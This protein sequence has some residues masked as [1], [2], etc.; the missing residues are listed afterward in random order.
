M[1]DED[2]YID[3]GLLNAILNADSVQPSSK[4]VT[5]VR[6]APLPV[7]TSPPSDSSSA[8]SSNSDMHGFVQILF[9]PGCISSLVSG[10]QLAWQDAHAALCTCRDARSSYTRTRDALFRKFIPGFA[11]GTRANHEPKVDIE[12]WVL[13]MISLSEPLHRYPT[14]ALTLLSSNG[15]PSPSEDSLAHKLE[16]LSL[17]HSRMMLLLRTRAPLVP[18][19][20]DLE[21]PPFRSADASSSKELSF[22]Q[23]LGYAAGEV[24]IGTPPTPPS[25]PGTL[26]GTR[27]NHQRHASAS[28]RLSRIFVSTPKAPP[29]APQRDKR[30]W[31]PSTVDPRE[32][33]MSRH[34]QSASM[35]DTES[36]RSIRASMYGLRSLASSDSGGTGTIPLSARSVHDPILASTRSRA[37]VLRLFV[38]C[39]RLDEPETLD[40]CSEQLREEGLWDFVSPGDVLCNLGHVPDASSS[41]TSSWIVVDSHRRL[42][43]W[44]PSDG[45]PAPL[46]GEDAL[47]CATPFYYAHLSSTAAAPSGGASPPYAGSAM[48]SRA[49]SVYSFAGPLSAS[50]PTLPRPPFFTPSHKRPGSSGGSTPT[51]PPSAWSA[52]YASP[53]TPPRVNPFSATQQPSPDPRWVLRIPP[54]EALLPAPAISGPAPANVNVQWTLSPQVGLVPLRSAGFGATARVKRY[55]WL[56]LVDLRRRGTRLDA[57]PVPPLPSWAAGGRSQQQPQKQAP[58]AAEE[59]LGVC[60]QREWVL[61][62]EG[63]REGRARL[64]A[65]LGGQ[66]GEERL[67]EIVRER[68]APGRLWMRLATYPTRQDPDEPGVNSPHERLAMTP[69]IPPRLQQ[70]QQQQQPRYQLPPVQFAAAAAAY[71]QDSKAH[72]AVALQQPPP[73]RERRVASQPHPD[74]ARR[75]SKRL[76]KRQPGDDQR[77][78]ASAERTPQPRLPQ[79]PREQ[80]PLP[81][82]S[83]GMQQWYGGDVAT[84][85]AQHPQWPAPR[86]SPS[87]VAQPLPVHAQ[88][89]SW[90]APP[91]VEHSLP[92]PPPP[93]Q[94]QPWSPVQQHNSRMKRESSPLNPNHRS[95]SSLPHDSSSSSL[96]AP[97][98]SSGS[99]TRPAPNEPMRMPA[100]PAV[101]AS[102]TRAL[103]ALPPGAA[104]PA[105]TPSPINTTLPSSHPPPP[106]P[107]SSFITLPS[108]SNSL[109]RSPPPPE[110]KHSP[111]PPLPPPKLSANTAN[112]PRDPSAPLSAPPLVRSAFGPATGLVPPPPPPPQTKRKLTRRKV[113]SALLPGR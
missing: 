64:E 84:P 58:S 28:S 21:D 82:V 39:A 38:P 29:P 25:Q 108:P 96:V 51:A 23:P 77:R 55:V 56:A 89:P 93:V 42:S 48:T 59:L 61:E 27:E 103:P 44:C 33:R 94:Q 10:G 113:V 19:Q 41:E 22:P 13:F 99:S 16:Q 87:T 17:A 57:P 100:L 1:R 101:L 35:S 26:R 24:Q 104:P 105:P 40:E 66:D 83:Q 80:R 50:T 74:T 79:Q 107:S 98:T 7:A 31:T 54:L 4:P 90:Y 111:P 18:R 43:V 91:A 53:P 72:M 95:S 20:S 11:Y 5:T 110:R 69:T 37:L 34:V 109:Q 106:P 2:V 6:R 60:W 62:A 97:S 88:Q 32:R 12:H 49:P 47:R 75:P 14:L 8:A 67:W 70:Q 65:I 78:T 81:P 92:P 86:A 45:T 71:A 85:V 76:S 112:L 9:E 36:R 63:T 73:E 52:S 30:Y 46:S 15:P 68:C 3:T 102:S